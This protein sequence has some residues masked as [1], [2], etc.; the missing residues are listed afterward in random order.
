MES[1]CD[2]LSARDSETLSLS[3]CSNLKAGMKLPLQRFVPHAW[4]SLSCLCWMLSHSKPSIAVVYPAP[5]FQVDSRWNGSVPQITTWIPHI[6][7]WIP[8]I[9]PWIPHIT[10]WIPHITPWIPHTPTIDSITFY[11]ESTSF[12]MDSTSFHYGFHTIPHGFHII[13]HGFHIIP[14]GFHIIPLWNP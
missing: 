3:E 12:H 14:H 1:S 2:P 11:M 5:T 13:P 4:K 7:P 9:T 10:P 8:H 6:T